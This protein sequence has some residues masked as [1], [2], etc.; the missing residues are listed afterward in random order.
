MNVLRS[1]TTIRE[2]SDKVL[3]DFESP[4][5]QSEEVQLQRERLGT[6]IY[7]ELTGTVPTPTPKKKKMPIWM[8]MRRF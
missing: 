3:F 5:D 7:E 4:A 8:Y 6:V 2:A 1:A